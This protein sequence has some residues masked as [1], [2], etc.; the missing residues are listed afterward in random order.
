M[1]GQHTHIKSSH[2]L[3]AYLQELGTSS[4]IRLIELIGYIPS[5]GPKLAPL[6]DA[7]VQVAQHKQQ[8]A[9]LRTVDCIQQVLHR[10]HVAIGQISN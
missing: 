4:Q 5:N 7:G 6:L 10:C 3:D 2:A 9:I 1:Q 8:L